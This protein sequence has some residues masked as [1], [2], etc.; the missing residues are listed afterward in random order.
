[1]L[2]QAKLRLMEQEVR[3]GYQFY[4]EGFDGRITDQKIDLELNFSGVV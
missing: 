1:M 2:Q 3:L 4:Y